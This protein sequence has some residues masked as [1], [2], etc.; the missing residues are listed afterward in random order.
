VTS[1]AAS[2]SFYWSVD[3]TEA[4]DMTLVSDASFNSRIFLAAAAVDR[5]RKGSMVGER[6][7]FWKR[8][9]GEGDDLGDLKGE[10]PSFPWNFIV[11]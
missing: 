2:K 5:A 3:G 10:N 4:H 8:S 7:N 9:E 11:P 6:M 1:F